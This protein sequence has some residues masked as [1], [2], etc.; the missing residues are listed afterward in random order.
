MDYIVL[1]PIKTTSQ[2][3][4]SFPQ[5]RIIKR[6]LYSISIALTFWQQLA[7]ISM[8]RASDEFFVRRILNILNK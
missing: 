4:L 7:V 3:Y 8:V 1:V 6:Q 5:W 2:T